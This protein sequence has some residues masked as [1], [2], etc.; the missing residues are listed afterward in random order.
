VN[1][2]GRLTSRLLKAG[3]S[4]L[5]D[6]GQEVVVLFSVLNV[7]NHAVELMPPQVQL[8]GKVKKGAIVH[9]SVWSNSEQLP[10]ED[11]RMSRR[12]LSS[13]GLLF[14]DQFAPILLSG[15]RHLSNIRA[16]MGQ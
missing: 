14:R 1:A 5:I 6:H 8:G 12:R 11:F 16:L 4:E 3:V 9:H 15:L 13:T 10:V 2:Q 7:Q